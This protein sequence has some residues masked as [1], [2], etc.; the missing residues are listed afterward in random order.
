MEVVEKNWV[1]K[2][3]YTCTLVT[4]KMS[5]ADVKAFLKAIEKEDGVTVAHG[6]VECVFGGNEAIV[7]KNGD[8][9]FEVNT[10]SDST[11]QATFEDFFKEFNIMGEFHVT[12]RAMNFSF[13]GRY[14]FANGSVTESEEKACYDNSDSMEVIKESLKAKGITV[15]VLF[16]EDGGSCFDL[17]KGMNEDE[18]VFKLLHDMEVASKM[19]LP[20]FDFA[21]DVLDVLQPRSIDDLRAFVALTLF[22]RLPDDVILTNAKLYADRRDG[23]APIPANLPESLAKTYGLWLYSEQKSDAEK[24]GLKPASAMTSSDG[25]C[26]LMVAKIKAAEMYE[27]LYLCAKYGVQ[28]EL[29]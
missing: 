19:Y 8:I 15:P 3:N 21:Q 2:K 9:V 22:N 12:A 25:P 26:L 16:S 10:D 24:C 17:A 20:G 28:K 5:E 23:K 1:E 7:E 18:A 13:L 14:H 29:K 4:E 6:Q 27:F 11:V